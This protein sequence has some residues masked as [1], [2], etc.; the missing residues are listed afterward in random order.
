MTPEFDVKEKIQ[1][2]KDALM[3]Q[4]PQMPTLLHSI[5][6]TLRKQPE[7]VTLLDDAE[8]GTLITALKKQ[9]GVE[10]V[11]KVSKPKAGSLKRISVDDL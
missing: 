10:L 6:S 8:I 11:A 2:L 7:V 9:T 1:Q 3:Q 4:H 5:H